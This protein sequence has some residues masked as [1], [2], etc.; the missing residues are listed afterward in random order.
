MLF[1]FVLEYGIRRVQI[2][3]D[4]LKLNGIHQLLVYANDVNILG[5][6][7]HS[8]KNT[9]GLLISSKEIGLQVNSDKTKNMVKSRDQNAGRS[10]NI[11]ID[12]SSFG[13]VEEFKY[14][15]TTLKNQNSIQEEIKS[16]LK[17]GNACCHSVQ[18][19][20]SSS[21]MSTD[22]KTEI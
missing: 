15:G 13:R 18:S 5:G 11:K 22:L 9:V 16:R 4:G 12:N 10:H 7:V 8:I 19:L 6:S 2:N 3:Q 17:S 20:L 1:N 14:L 21:L